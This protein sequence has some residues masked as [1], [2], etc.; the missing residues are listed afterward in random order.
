MITEIRPYTTGTNELFAAIKREFTEAEL[1]GCCA[2][3]TGEEWYDSNIGWWHPYKPCDL[4]ATPTFGQIL[5]PP[6]DNPTID[7][8]RAQMLSTPP[9]DGWTDCLVFQS[10]SEI[11][12]LYG[13][14][15]QL[16]LHSEGSWGRLSCTVTVEATTAGDITAEVRRYIDAV[17]DQ[18]AAAGHYVTRPNDGGDHRPP[19]HP[20]GWCTD[21]SSRSTENLPQ[22]TDPTSA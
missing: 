11:W 8:I 9:P 16:D 17:S 1:L 15:G 20:T 19:T 18:D 14:D 6:N 3:D 13:R 4:A 5:F 10:H 12:S 22:P 7:Q 21:S 2:T